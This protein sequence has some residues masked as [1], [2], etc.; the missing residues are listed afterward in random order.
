MKKQ[1]LLIVLLCCSLYVNTILL[2]IFNKKKQAVIETS[3]S[4]SS[5]LDESGLKDVP[6]T[7]LMIGAGN[8]GYPL[9]HALI[10]EKTS[11][12]FFSKIIVLDAHPIVQEETQFAKEHVNQIEYIQ[13]DMRDELILREIFNNSNVRG[14]IVM[15]CE[16]EKDTCQDINTQVLM[17]QITMSRNNPW[18]IFA[19]S[20]EVYGVVKE[21]QKFRPMGFQNQSSQTTCPLLSTP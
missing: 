18:L 20:R 21:F 12:P 8:V 3:L 16:L 14:V 13:G 2:G 7:L 4:T 11:Q 17:K 9:L 15:W 10:S 1:L 19:S 5:E 6:S